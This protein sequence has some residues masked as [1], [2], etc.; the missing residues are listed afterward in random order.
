MEAIQNL[1]SEHRLILRGI[2]A[3]EAFVAGA[4]GGVDGREELGRFVDFIRGY[5]DRLHHGKEEDVLF[6]AMVDEGFSREQGPVAV[7]LSEHDVGREHVAVLSGLAAS[8]VPW[9]REDQ[10]IL[11]GAA[12]AYAEL[13]RLHIQKE[14]RI[15]YP[16]A[17]ARLSPGA[18]AQ[19]D[20]ACAAL[21]AKV[22]RDGTRG[23]LER[24]GADLVARYLASEA[25]GV[26]SP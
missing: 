5:A 14:D 10:E 16:M 1:M 12:R 19:V 8:V 4:A 23:R 17:E 9:T 24:L 3:L 15:L 20:A 13:L 18:Q 26:G 25:A 7:M 21:D 11:E 22:G 2:D 6:V